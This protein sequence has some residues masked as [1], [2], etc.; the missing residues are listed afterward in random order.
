MQGDKERNGTR[1]GNRMENLRA[2]RAMPAAGESPRATRCPRRGA[3]NRQSEP[4][5]EAIR[6]GAVVTG[7]ISTPVLLYGG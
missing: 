2:V 1:S 3:G 4:R 6:V 5:A 7:V